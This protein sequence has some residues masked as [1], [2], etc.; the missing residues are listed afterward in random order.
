[1]SNT[2]II[3]EVNTKLEQNQ[4]MMIMS[5]AMVRDL[6][7]HMKEGMEF[8]QKIHLNNKYKINSIDNRVTQGS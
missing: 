4:S 3:K 7:E 6:F 1:M 5:L 2:D 8:K